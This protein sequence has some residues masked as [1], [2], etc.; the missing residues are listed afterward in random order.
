[1]SDDRARWNAR[2]A[3]GAY[4]TITHPS[5]Y[6]EANVGTL[7][8]GRALDLACGA[9][10]NALFLAAVGFEVDA[11]DISNVAL[12]R[13]S[14]SA[15]ERGLQIRWIEADLT[16]PLTKITPPY[17]LITNI[18]YVD[19]DLVRQA[20]TWLAPGGAI[21]IEQHLAL[22]TDEEIVGPRSAHFRVAPGALAD[23]VAGLTILD[24]SEGL[25]E[26]PDG[27]IAALARIIARREA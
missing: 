17:D 12:E 5:A 9:G 10:R 13:A 18:R 21:L 14:A 24:S 8:R 27:R 22:D 16:E 26:D 4:Q 3:E 20:I 15:A 7:N 11:V 19:F 6:L 1:M 2:Y 23:T 25:I